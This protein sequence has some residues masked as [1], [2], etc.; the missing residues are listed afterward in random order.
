MKRA[1][2]LS[3]RGDGAGPFTP[4]ISKAKAVAAVAFRR[5]TREMVEQYSGNPVFWGSVPAVLS[6]QALPSTDGVPIVQKG[7]VIGA[8][9]CSGGTGEQ[10][11][12]CAQSAAKTITQ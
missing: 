12:T 9:G 4:E 2:V 10:D 11:D 8:I 1:D 3:A 7:R 6:G 5:S